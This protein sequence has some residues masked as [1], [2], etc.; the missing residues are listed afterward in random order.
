MATFTQRHCVKVAMLQLG[1]AAAGPACAC[2]T[3]PGA[4]RGSVYWLRDSAA[5]S[6][7]VPI[8][9]V[10][11]AGIAAGRAASSRPRS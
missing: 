8:G 11:S 5:G 7:R 2:P 1:W 6:M 9:S 10:D 3:P 4:P